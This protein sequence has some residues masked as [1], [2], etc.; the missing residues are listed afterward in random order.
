MRKVRTTA[1]V[2]TA[3]AIIIAGG[4]TAAVDVRA[5]PISGLPTAV[6]APSA[7]P[8]ALPS[9]SAPPTTVAPRPTTERP[10]T[11]KH[12]TSQ[13]PTSQHAT[14]KPPINTTPPTI[15]PPTSVSLPTITGAWRTA[16][17]TANAALTYAEHNGYHTAIAVLDTETGQYVSAGDA[18]S[19]YSSESVVKTMIAARLLASGQMTG[20]VETTAWKMI[21]QSDD[22]SA[23]ALYG[24]VGGD[25]IV[26]W[27]AS[28]F[29]IANLGSPPPRPGWWGGTRITASGLV[30][31]YAAIKRDPS[32]GGWLFN[33][34]SHATRYGSDGTFQLFGLPSAS[35][36]VAVKAGWG[37]DFGDGSADFNSTGLVNG[38]RYAVAILMRGPSASYGA[39]ISAVLTRC[40]ALLMPGGRIP[41]PGPRKG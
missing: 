19:V 41:A 2:A 8:A 40:A 33:A 31:L 16:Q 22:A 32:I 3:A 11:T 39:A 7:A 10:S 17:Q 15:K 12:P 36:G 23:N 13:H 25:G 18:N 6:P 4:L 20:T 30:H 27:A 21:T 37:F 28:Y 26:T 14:S 24:R 38:D 9:T 1:I 35:T 29:H 34:M 5:Q